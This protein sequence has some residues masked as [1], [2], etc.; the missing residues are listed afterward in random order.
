MAHRETAPFQ[1]Q[2]PQEIRELVQQLQAKQGKGKGKSQVSVK[3]ATFTLPSGRNVDSWRMQDWDYKKPNLPTYA[4]GLFTYINNEGAHEIAVRGYDKFF[5]HGEVTKTNWDN[6]EK[7]TRGPYELSVKENGCIIFIAGL[8]DGTL[9]VCSKH[10]TGPRED[11]NTSHAIWGEK[12]IDRHLATVGKTREDL[13]RT[14]RRM[15]ATAVAELCDDEFEEHVLPY[16]REEAGLYLHGINLNLPEFATYPGPLVDKFADEWGMKKV[17]YVMEDDIKKVKRFLDEVAETGNYDGRDTEGFVI[18]CQARDSV[19]DSHDW[20]DWFFKYKFEEPY[21][22]YRQWRECTKSM[23]AGKD[24][25]IK[26]HR[27]ITQ[28][29]LRFARYRFA[30]NPQLAKEYNKNH[31]I[32]ALREEFLKAQGVNGADIIR[33]EIESGEEVAD[34]TN[35]VVLVPIATIG[36]GKT[37]IALGLVKLFGW[38]H[39]QNDNIQGKHRR[40]QRFAESIEALLEVHPAVFADRNNHQKRE[41]QQLIQD[42]SKGAPK[43]KFVA[44]HFV[45]DPSDYN[46]VRRIMQ[47]RV[48]SRGDNHQ[49]IRSNEKGTHEVVGIMDGFLHRFQPVDASSSPDDAFDLVIDLSATKSSRENLETVVTKLYEAY[50]KLF[51]PDMPT[52]QDMDDA[53]ADALNDYK[54][55]IKHDLSFGKKQPG[56][57]ESRNKSM[58]DGSNAPKPKAPKLEY[59]AVKLDT[60]RI[61][62]ILS[63]VFSDADEASANFFWKLKEE[64]RIQPQFHVTLIHR[65]SAAQ[66]KDYWEKLC[67]IQRAPWEDAV[68]KRKGGE[69]LEPELSKCDVQLERLVW[70]DRVMCFVVR[71]AQTEGAKAGNG[72]RVAFE[73]V[74]PVAHV[75]VGTAAP[76]IK[77]KES[78]DLLK[79]WLEVG[80]GNGTGIHE[81]VV[82]GFRVLPGS[83]R[84]VLQK[85]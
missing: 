56:P 36:C 31:G 83:V 75:T 14:L 25:R 29:Y 13:A 19:R 77:P 27:K 21:L 32:I 26:K 70:D 50:P 84:G 48:L 7:N 38:G 3:K 1:P 76:S 24:P 4:R 74:N 42:I 67:D 12:W 58:Q 20:H 49:T 61:I 57:K 22:M 9:L 47:E 59:F 85:H 39:F 64:N 68:S 34:V 30:Q 69:G 80:S 37:T 23:I 66:H 52:A 6:V 8:D 15:N 71:L 45:H 18:R 79:R 63:A 5:N 72:E 28:E 65:A 51:P 46:E 11:P 54:P 16:G 33:Q 41:R 78:N 43:A 35:N 40:P 81:V 17:V 44:L 60:S 53:I 73:T 55:D 62:E 2:N 82:S 10:S